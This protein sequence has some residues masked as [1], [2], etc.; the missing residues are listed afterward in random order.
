MMSNTS[1]KFI[2]TWVFNKKT[3]VKILSYQFKDFPKKRDF[4]EYNSWK[5]SIKYRKD[6]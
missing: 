6:I 5:H 3:Y 1:W 2:K 4:S